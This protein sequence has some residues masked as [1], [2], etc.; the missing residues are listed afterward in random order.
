MPARSSNPQFSR[1][2]ILALASCKTLVHFG[3]RTVLHI[4]FASTKDPFMGLKSCFVPG[5]TSAY[6]LIAHESYSP[7]SRLAHPGTTL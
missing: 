5:N 1:S 4:M 7:Y 3:D 6:V 2:Q